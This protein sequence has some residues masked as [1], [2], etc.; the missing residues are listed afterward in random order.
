MNSRQSPVFHSDLQGG[1]NFSYLYIPVINLNCEL[2]FT[3]A[4]QVPLD[5]KRALKWTDSLIVI[6]FIYIFAEG[7]MPVTDHIPLDHFHRLY[8]NNAISGGE[9]P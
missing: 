6:G 1:K 8:T 2:L 4:L 3:Q 9:W 5:N 7:E